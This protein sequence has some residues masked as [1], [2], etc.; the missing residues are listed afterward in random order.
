MTA[1]SSVSTAAFL[2]GTIV[3][4]I[5]P[6]KDGQTTVRIG[7]PSGVMTMV[8]TVLKNGDNPADYTVP[9][10]AVQRTARRIMD[11][12]VYIRN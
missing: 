5:A 11:G 9:G 12:F 1:A 10:V 8:P 4:K 7:H 2:E 6:I 3:N